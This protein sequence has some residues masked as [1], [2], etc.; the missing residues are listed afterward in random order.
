MYEADSRFFGLLVSSFD[1]QT[2][3]TLGREVNSKSIGV[4][5]DRGLPNR[6]FIAMQEYP[7]EKK[8]R[9]VVRTSGFNVELEG[10]RGWRCNSLGRR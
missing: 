7:N 1:A 4:S 3:L 10:G 9:E 2:G 6:T 5:A 8:S